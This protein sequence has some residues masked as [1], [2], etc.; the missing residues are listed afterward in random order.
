MHFDEFITPW[1]EIDSEDHLQWKNPKTFLEGILQSAADAPLS[2]IHHCFVW[3]Y[4][5]CNLQ[6]K[7]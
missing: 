6:Q 3:Q 1:L 5:L 2:Q 7:M 4:L